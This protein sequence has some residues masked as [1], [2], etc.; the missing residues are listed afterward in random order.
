VRLSRTGLLAA[1]RFRRPSCLGAGYYSQ[2][3]WRVEPGPACPAHV[4]WEHSVPPSP[5]S[6]CGRLSRPLRT[7]RCSDAPWTIG[8]PRGWPPCG[9]EAMRSPT[10]LPLLSPPTT[11]YGGPQPPLGQRTNALPRCGLLGRASPRHRHSCPYGA[12]SSFREG[13][14]PDGL[15]GALCTLHLLR[16]VVHLLRSCHTRAEWWVR[17]S[18]ADQGSI[19]LSRPG[20]G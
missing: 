11:L 16:A 6:P 5:P 20:T 18:S 17:P 4:A 3:G 7:L 19:G 12:V 8:L 10:F 9:Q 2:R 13:G 15:R 14:P 1:T